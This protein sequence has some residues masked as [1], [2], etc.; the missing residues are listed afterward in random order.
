MSYQSASFMIFTA[1]SLLLFYVVP[2]HKQKYVLLSA[3]ILFYCFS[4]LKYLPFIAVT[5]LATFFAG[6]AMGAVYEKE[7]ELLKLC[8]T[9]AE[10]KE[11]RAG[12]KKKARGILIIGLAVSIALLVVCKYTGFN[13]NNRFPGDQRY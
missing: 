7:K 13:G 5:L 8:Q 12:C 9:P 4:G 3:N 6:K 11:V 10:K 1:V 2:R